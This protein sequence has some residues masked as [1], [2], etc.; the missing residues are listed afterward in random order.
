[1]KIY[2]PFNSNDFNSV[3]TTMSISPRIYY[4]NRNYSFKR[5]TKTF[6]NP[7]D[8]TLLGFS[9]IVF[10]NR[11][12]DLE[13]GFP[14]NLEVDIRP[15][16]CI[17]QG[18]LENEI[19][20]FFVHNT[21]YLYNGFKII[22]RSDAEREIVFSKSL[23]SIET[24]FTGLAKRNSNVLNELKSLPAFINY[25]ELNKLRYTGSININTFEQERRINK[26]QGALVGFL[27]GNQKNV[28]PEFTKLKVSIKELQNIASVFFNSINAND[29][30]NNQ[31]RLIECLYRIHSNIEK[32][33]P[34]D[35]ILILTNHNLTPALLSDLKS[36]MIFGT[37]GLE[38]LKEGLISLNPIDLPLQLKIEKL[39]RTISYK[40]NSKFSEST[41]KKISDL[42]QS[43][44]N[45]VETIINVEIT[46][47]NLKADQILQITRIEGSALLQF[48]VPDF[49]KKEERQ[50]FESILKFLINEDSILNA[51]A[52]FSNRD[53]YLTNIGVYLNKEI[54]GFGNSSERQY[55]LTLLKSFKSLR[56]QFD[57][58]AS[59]LDT[60]KSLALL[61]TSGRDMIKY[62]DG[63]NNST[64][65]NIQIPLSIWGA[66][67]GFAS[68]PKLITNEVLNSSSNEQMISNLLSKAIY[69]FKI[70]TFTQPVYPPVTKPTSFPSVE[71]KPNSSGIK[72]NSKEKAKIDLFLEKVA[73]IKKMPK[74]TMVNDV[75]RSC[76]KVTEELSPTSSN[77]V[78]YF[79]QTLK[80]QKGKLKGYSV[81]TLTEIAQLYKGI[82]T[83]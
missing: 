35:E 34:L 45:E 70:E 1:M 4:A 66:T 13:D 31:D 26:L 69:Q 43:V 3:F 50:Y 15:E 29:Y 32:L 24:K 36:A 12:F 46:N 25:E 27:I 39:K 62:M 28:G 14:I 48:E 79:E 51:E 68:L 80:E 16:N 41:S 57:I 65:E 2:I 10:T 78:K 20:L 18:T 8:E 17:K 63:V 21:I 44:C 58:D 33:I 52:L 59:K 56:M 30:K 71:K 77:R 47:N 40:F 38:V 55:I 67:Y 6:L 49:I 72:I 73:K 7:L 5:A 76:I 37:N 75:L 61:L 22:F 83:D 64:I 53:T 74:D 42:L 82:F 11:D 9:R 60:L 81:K 23:K 54:A 19:D